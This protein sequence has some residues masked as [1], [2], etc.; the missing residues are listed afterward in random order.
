MAGLCLP[1]FSCYTRTVKNVTL[2]IDE[3]TLRRARHIAVEK[4]VSLSRLL[5]EYLHEIVGRSERYAEARKKALARMKKGLPMG[6]RAR[7]G[8]KRDELH[9]R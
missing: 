2:A 1:Q 8:W 5:S 3:E 9:E 4:G 7:R 6:V